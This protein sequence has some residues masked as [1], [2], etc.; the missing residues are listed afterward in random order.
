M[1]KFSYIKNY[2]QLTVEGYYDEN[3]T[4]INV[5][6]LP[7]DF[8]TT[9][10]LGIPFVWYNRTNNYTPKDDES[11]EFILVVGRPSPNTLQ[12]LRAQQ[13]TL[14]TPK[15]LTNKLYVLELVISQK[16]FD[17][18]RGVLADVD[19]LKHS[20]DNKPVLDLISAPFTTALKSTYDAGMIDARVPVAHTQNASTIINDSGMAGSTV[21]DV[22]ND[23]NAGLDLRDLQLT[24]VKTGVI[25]NGQTAT[26]ESFPVGEFAVNKWLIHVVDQTHTT[27]LSTE[28]LAHYNGS[29][30]DYVEYAS[31]GSCSVSF[32]VI[33]S[34][35]NMQLIATATADAQNVL[36]I[37]NSIKNF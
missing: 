20:H 29:T 33:I 36:A 4:L 14:A 35:S 7:D 8:P 26:I 25:N 16:H 11:K 32:A 18:I 12:I 17:E 9:F 22:F 37:R 24:V 34:G 6:G 30:V 2:L 19:S 5:S 1:L 15:A 3:A 10:D 27:Q 21:K 13:E 23:I 28:I 31:I